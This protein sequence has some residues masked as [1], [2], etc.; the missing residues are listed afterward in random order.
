MTAAVPSPSG[1]FPRKEVVYIL[2]GYSL[3]DIR[4][5]ITINNMKYTWYCLQ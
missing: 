5:V 2:L 1:K 3:T 4:N